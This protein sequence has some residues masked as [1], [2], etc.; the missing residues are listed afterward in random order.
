MAV[1]DDNDFCLFSVIHTDTSQLHKLLRN[2]I[3]SLFSDQTSPWL[4][5]PTKDLVT[6]FHNGLDAEDTQ[7]KVKKILKG[8]TNSAFQKYYFIY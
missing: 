5:L 3:R 6:F 7:Y 4:V 1:F 2:G 8:N